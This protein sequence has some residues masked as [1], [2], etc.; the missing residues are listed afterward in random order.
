MMSYFENRY[1]IRGIYFLDEPE[2]ALSPKSQLKLLEIIQKNTQEGQAQFFIATH[3]PILLA[4]EHA[5]I[6]SFDY[7]SVKVIGRSGPPN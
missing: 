5:D 6:F 4:Y 7:E 1:K 3:L 2:T